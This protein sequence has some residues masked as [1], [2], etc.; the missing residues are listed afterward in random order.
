MS[1]L[2]NISAISHPA[3]S[4][5]YRWKEIFIGGYVLQLTH[6][7]LTAGL[8]FLVFYIVLRRI[9]FGRKIQPAFPASADVRRE[10]FYSLLS[11]VIFSG[12][13]V[14]SSILER[15]HLTRVYYHIGQHGW[16]YFIFSIA[17]LIVLHDTWFYWSH[18][19]LHWRPL[20][21]LAHRVHHR[22]HNPTPWAAFAFHP[23]EALI[24]AL[25]YPLVILFVPIH[26]GAA[27]VWLIYMTVMNVG[28]HLGFELFPAGFLRHRWLRWHNTSVHH[29]MHHSH[30]HCNY[31][32]YFNVW[33]RLM[34][35][36]HEKYEQLF[37][38][39]VQADG[40]PSRSLPFLK[41]RT[42]SLQE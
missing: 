17:A 8:A 32:L 23:V 35:T 34:G 28:G 21:L 20:F 37:N 6:Y 15:L 19:A 16:G 9:L 39:V 33:D 14:F 1:I 26:P 27:L 31:G 4:A 38:R 36:N 5:F 30:I 18:R 7:L 29:N 10:I 40:G 3:H 42:P 13:G 2:A 41:G 22:S 11:L 24:E 25:I 12:V